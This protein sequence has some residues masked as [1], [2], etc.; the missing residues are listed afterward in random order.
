MHCLN[1]VA[2]E[3]DVYIIP[4]NFIEGGKIFGGMFKIRNAIE[5]GVLG[6]GTGLLILKLPFSLTTKIV[7][8]CIIS[9]PLVIFGLIGVDGMSLTEYLMN[10]LKFLKNRRKLFRSNANC[11]T[12]ISRFR[13][14]I[15]KNRFLDKTLGKILDK[16]RIRKTKKFS[17]MPHSIR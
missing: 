7:I 15:K 8:M 4:P 17:I 5:A 13:L 14:K 12:D 1:E 11:E 6:G 10:V 2:E 16:H 3:L 9:L